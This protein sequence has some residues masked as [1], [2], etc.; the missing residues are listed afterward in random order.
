MLITLEAAWRATDGGAALTEEEG[1]ELIERELTS[2]DELQQDRKI[3]ARN[4]H[5]LRHLLRAT[6]RG[7]SAAAALQVRKDNRRRV[8][9]QLANF[10]RKRIRAQPAIAEWQQKVATDAGN[11]L[12]GIDHSGG[13]IAVRDDNAAHA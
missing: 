2:H 6:A 13:H 8:A 10:L 5:D 12:H 11:V 4:N 3:D 7:E 9:D 1:H